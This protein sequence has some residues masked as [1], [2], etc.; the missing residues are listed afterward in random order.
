MTQQVS[1]ENQSAFAKLQ[2]CVQK[3]VFGFPYGGDNGVN[4]ALDCG[5]PVLNNC[6]CATSATSTASSFLTSC[7]DNSCSRGDLP[8][9]VTVA[10]SFYDSYCVEAGYAVAGA[11]TTAVASATTTAITG[12]ETSVAMSPGSTGGKYLFLNYSANL[13]P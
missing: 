9:A 11:P 13:R 4:Q 2:Q 7:V 12:A 10:V 1:I 8:Q 3:C 5:W 6:Y